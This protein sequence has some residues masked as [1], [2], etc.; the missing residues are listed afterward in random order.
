MPLI[1]LLFK[2]SAIVS[3]QLA[4]CVIKTG[5]MG[6][7]A[8]LLSKSNKH[9]ICVRIQIINISICSYFVILIETGCTLEQNLLVNNLRWRQISTRLP[10]I[11]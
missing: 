10:L 5:H 11:N 6:Q 7:T 2:Y 4:W 3:S 1:Y 9:G 8:S